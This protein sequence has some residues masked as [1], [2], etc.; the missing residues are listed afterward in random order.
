MYYEITKLVHLWYLHVYGL[1]R[2]HSDVKDN[3][4]YGLRQ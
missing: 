1:E 3:S 2:I 4:E